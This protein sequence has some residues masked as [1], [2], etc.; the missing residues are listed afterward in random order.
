[1]YKLLHIITDTNIGGAGRLLLG[2]LRNFDREKFD[3][4]VMLPRGSELCPLIEELCYPVIE[5]RH[6]A[7][8][9][10]EA[11]ALGEYMREIR[12]AKPD[13]VHCHGALSARLAAAL[14]GV[15]VRVY[16]RHCAYPPQRVMRSFPV[17]QAIG[18][19]S[20][21]LSHGIIAVAEA[22]KQDLLDMGIDGKKITVIINGVEPLEKLDSVERE[23]LRRELGFD[24]DDIA[25][26]IFA[27]LESCKGHI[28][29]L[30][31][32]RELGEESKIKLL[33][34]GEGSLGAELRREAAALG[35]AEKVIFAGF[36]SDVT[37]YMNISDIN[38][39][40]SVGTETSS[41]ALSE[42]MSIGLPAVVSDYG[43][44]PC[45]VED[46]VSG[47]VVPRADPSALAAVLRRLEKD[48]E[49]RCRMGRA[50]R[51]RY[52]RKFTAASMTR[53]LEDFYLKLLDS[54]KGR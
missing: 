27:R 5:T 22:A 10:F 50:A 24:G 28:Y 11:G 37:P 17:K 44:N 19:V 42:G 46:G 49:L 23:R 39:N 26:G 43:G 40:C 33:I 14:A 45:M 34:C 32:L 4:T 13:I 20:G 16:T 54:K 36:C 53:Q 29:L 2:Q 31:A 3:I 21:G 8:K 48:G 47:F 30:R 35:I 12:R 41:L 51:E 6:G 52:E 1:M 7:D 25:V 9:S 38:V 18:A 15:G